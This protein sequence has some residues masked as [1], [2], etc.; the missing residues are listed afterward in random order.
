MA[1]ILASGS[2]GDAYAWV[3]A[4]HRFDEGRFVLSYAK[5]VDPAS[6]EQAL[7]AQAGRART[8]K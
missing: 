4:Y 5:E 6:A 8:T 3:C 1:G 7:A 2:A